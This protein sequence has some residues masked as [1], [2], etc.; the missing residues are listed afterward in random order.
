MERNMPT[1]MHFNKYSINEQ[2]LFSLHSFVHACDYPR[3]VGTAGGLRALFDATQGEGA[4]FKK[5]Q[6]DR[7]C[8]HLNSGPQSEWRHLIS[9]STVA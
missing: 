2:C 6:C 5:K 4:I 7:L 1:A 3:P 8:G 9:I